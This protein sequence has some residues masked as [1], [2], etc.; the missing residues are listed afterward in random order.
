MS[1]S[2]IDQNLPY[3]ISKSPQLP[4]EIYADEFADILG[5]QT[6]SCTSCGWLWLYRGPSL[7]LHQR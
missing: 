2:E 7:C 6:E 1:H 5:V 4:L 3:P